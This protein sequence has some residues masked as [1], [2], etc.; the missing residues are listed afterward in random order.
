V[1]TSSSPS[2]VAN[3][4]SFIDASPS[5][6]H[7]VSTAEHR[8]AA[9]GFSQL[10]ETEA[11]TTSAGKWFI[12]RDGAL[13][14]W[15][16][17]GGPATTAFR[18]IGAH[19]DSPNLR[20][21][22]QPDRWSSGFQQLGVEV[23]GGVL[24]NS[25]LDR[26]LG[27]SGRVSHR[28]SLGIATT[29]FRIDEPILRVPQLAI[30]L[31]REINSKGL[32]LNAQ[33]HMSPVWGIG[34]TAS[35]SFAQFLAEE[36]SIDAGDVLAWDAMAHDL[37]PGAVV[38]RDKS[39]VASARID[40]QM[41]CWAGLTALLNV[42]EDQEVAETEEAVTPL[43]CLFDHEEVGSQ[44]RS[45]AGS[46]M[47]ATVLERIVTGAGGT[48]EDLLRSLADSWCVSADG[49]HATHP[50][51]AERHEPNHQIHLNAGPVV[52][53]NA[54]ER[55]A[56]SAPTHA[57]F[58]DACERASVPFQKFVNRTDLACGS[59]IGPVTSARLGIRTVDAGLAQLA[60]H[61]ARE[62]AGALDVPMFVAAL[63]AALGTALS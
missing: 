56:T 29:L 52:K 59:T 13:I 37:T 2:S 53:I 10:Q 55:Y 25:W 5:P 33:S 8:L 17:R 18:L 20:I 16:H 14:A 48:R 46:S 7:V 27:L 40:N 43:L 11:W 24:L 61:S 51:Y 34:E 35:T 26:D 4:L 60:M 44:S 32:K 45:G 63:S 12:K 1:P 22:P 47:L 19:T 30:H 3:L 36:L 57:F 62:T 41:S 38:G 49:A 23:Y 28:T 9:E 31:D 21:K 39:M 15:I 54:N 6:Y 50:N 42:A 58:V